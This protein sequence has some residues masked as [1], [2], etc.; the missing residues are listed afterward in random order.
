[1]NAI[2]SSEGAVELVSQAPAWEATL[3]SIGN[4]DPGYG[5]V[6]YVIP[7]HLTAENLDSLILE[8]QAL[9]GGNGG[10]SPRVSFA[11]EGKIVHCAL[12]TPP[13]F[14]DPPEGSYVTTGNLI[15]LEDGRYDVSQFGGS[16]TT[17]WTDVKNLLGANLITGISVVADGGWK[18][19]GNKGQV[20]GVRNMQIVGGEP[21]PGPTPPVTITAPYP[22]F[23]S[24]TAEGRYLFQLRDGTQFEGTY[25]HHYD[26]GCLCVTRDQREGYLNPENIICAWEIEWPPE[27]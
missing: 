16:T 13:N 6:E 2:L 1:V 23:Q 3:T 8:Y 9:Q 12:G 17:G 20:I 24:L 11:C 4:A 5:M 19:T 15:G 26:D 7:G 21:L 27:T 22:T 18:F 10:G 14:D 25:H